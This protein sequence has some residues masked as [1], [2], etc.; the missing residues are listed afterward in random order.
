[1]TASPYIGDESIRREEAYG[2][3]NWLLNEAEDMLL[4]IFS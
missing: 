1:M 3:I 4:V 2:L